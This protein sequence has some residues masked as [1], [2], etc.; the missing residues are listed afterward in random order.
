MSP[1]KETHQGTIQASS[2]LLVALRT[3]GLVVVPGA[4]H[5]ER[6]AVTAAPGA[7]P[8]G[9]PRSL[10][11]ECLRDCSV[12]AP[13]PASCRW[14]ERSATYRD[15]TRRTSPC[16]PILRTG[17][18]IER[19]CR[20]PGRRLFFSVR[21]E[22]MR[23]TNWCSLWTD[24]LCHSRPRCCPRGCPRTPGLHRIPGR[25]GRHR[26]SRTAGAGRL[27]RVFQHFGP[28]LLLRL[29]AGC[30]CDSPGCQQQ[31]VDEFSV[32]AKASRH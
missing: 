10:V 16:S 7:V 26:N 17:D 12:Y 30:L 21:R 3:R 19:M 14:R 15:G 28:S 5:R 29:W 13:R 24:H 11:A 18:G 1:F 6:T 4:G 9:S 32:S 20:G 31:A 22:G 23:A 2:S 27:H 8:G 25:P